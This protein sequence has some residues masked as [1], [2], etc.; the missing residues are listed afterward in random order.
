MNRPPMLRFRTGLYAHAR[1]SANTHRHQRVPRLASE[2]FSKGK[3]VVPKCVQRGWPGQ[4]LYPQRGSQGEQ[5]R[6]PAPFDSSKE[7]I[8]L[9]SPTWLNISDRKRLLSAGYPT[10]TELLSQSKVIPELSFS[11]C[12]PAR[13][14]LM[15]PSRRS[16]IRDIVGSRRTFPAHPR[17]TPQGGSYHAHC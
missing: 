15:R 4:S 8:S 2:A 17:G 14:T 10:L 5:K 9:L 7:S 12:G 13:G 3:F 1:Q 11:D 6:C 16:R